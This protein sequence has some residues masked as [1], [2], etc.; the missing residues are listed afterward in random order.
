MSDRRLHEENAR[1]SR[2]HPHNAA[3]AK[4]QIDD[5]LTYAIIG[6][7]QKVHRPLGAGF[8]ESTYARALTKELMDQKIPFVSQPEYEVHY[9]NVL[10]G[11][12]RPD[13]VVQNKVILE[14]KAVSALGKEHIAQAISY[15]KASGLPVALLINFGAPS[16]EFHRFQN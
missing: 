13:V 3:P 5:P 2:E 16:L 11:T 7:A 4:G 9:E 14:L 8:L 12:Y 6:A 15:L 1:D 10:C